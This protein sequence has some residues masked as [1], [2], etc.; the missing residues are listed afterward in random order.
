M[1]KENR[2]NQ[3]HRELLGVC[4]LNPWAGHDS[5]VRVQMMASQIGQAL[6]V[7]GATERRCQTGMEREYGKYTFSVKSPGDPGTEGG[8]TIIK[9][10]QRYPHKIGYDSIKFNPQTVV[11]YEDVKTKEVGIINLP[12]YFSNHQYF[13]F[14]YKAKPSISDIKVGSFIPYGT[15]LLDS[16]SITD[17]GGY[18]YGVECNMAFMSHPAVSE[19]GVL[20]SRD[21]LSKFNFKTFETRVVEWGSKRF[22]LNLYGDADTYKPFPDIGDVIRPDGILMGLRTYDK[23]LAVVE[24]SVYDLMEP[25]LIFDKL[26]YAGGAG[27]RV[28]D[29]K[30]QRSS[31]YNPQIPGGS[32]DSQADKYEFARQQFYQSILAEYKRLKSNRG[33]GLRLTPEFHR[34]LVEAQAIIDNDPQHLVKLYR[35]APLDDY[36]IEFIIEYDITPV[37]GFKL[38]GMHGKKYCHFN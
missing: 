29:I 34:L 7:G 28:I 11:I 36:R 8:I 25:D 21:V 12:N 17:N 30:V 10:I 9:V 18:K 22:P 26:T 27:G 19:D 2:P 32:I 24:Q 6:V 13:G 20:I 14:E 38:T 4:G 5:S 31:K 15:T 33:E 37:T 3:I 1:N 23:E 16:P 35:K